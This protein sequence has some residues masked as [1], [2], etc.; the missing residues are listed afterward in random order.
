MSTKPFKV[1]LEDFI[2]PEQDPQ[3][4]NPAPS[5][6]A[7]TPANEPA[8]APAPVQAGAEGEIGRAHV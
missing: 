6:G 7:P 1:S 2:S 8:P 3:P 4:A 5:E